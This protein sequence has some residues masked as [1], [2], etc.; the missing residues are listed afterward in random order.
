MGDASVMSLYLSQNIQDKRGTGD[1]PKRIYKK[2]LGGAFILE[3]AHAGTL[4]SEV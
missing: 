4:A 2:E 1:G 3:K